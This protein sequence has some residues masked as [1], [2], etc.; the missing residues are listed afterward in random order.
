MVQASGLTWTIFRLAAALPFAIQL[1]PGMFDVPLDN[2]IEY[3][4]SR[5]VALAIANAIVDDNVWRRLL[6][7]GG[8]PRCQ[9]YF[10]EIVECILGAVGVGMLPDEAFT[11]E[12]FPTD[13]LDTTVSQR[14]LRY[15]QH[16]LDDYLDEMKVALGSK[17][18]LVK[19]FR[20]L[21]RRWLLSKSPYYAKHG[22][23]SRL[24]RC[25][26]SRTTINPS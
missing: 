7:I 18:V 24:G 4:H 5:D 25:T 9:Y 11:T 10:R 26:V 20:P 21:V 16:T 22:V 1:D 6:L 12:P 2:R 17:R 3:V 15:Q 14:L 8:G 13:W 19:A 23:R